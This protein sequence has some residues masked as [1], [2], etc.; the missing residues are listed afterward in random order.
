M[1]VT[2][3][4]EETCPQWTY[5]TLP[6]QECLEQVLPQQL[7]R[8]SIWVT[9]PDLLTCGG[10]PK[11]HQSPGTRPACCGLRMRRETGGEKTRWSER[12]AEE[13]FR[14]SHSPTENRGENEIA[15]ASDFSS[16]NTLHP[17]Y[18]SSLPVP[19]TVYSNAD[20]ADS[21]NLSTAKPHD[22]TQLSPS[23]NC[24]LF[25]FVYF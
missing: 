25:G 6:L 2:R 16:P 9:D 15:G 12:P 21:K 1:N 20:T 3:N 17:T 4:Q 11:S 24:H 14:T 7:E 5:C 22:L 18:V 19:D 10:Q 13:C 8:I 23:T